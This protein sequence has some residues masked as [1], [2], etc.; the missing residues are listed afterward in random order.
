MKRTN[1]R[2]ENTGMDSREQRGKSEAPTGKPRT[3]A[4]RGGW[5]SFQRGEEGGQREGLVQNC[6]RSTLKAPTHWTARGAAREISIDKIH[7]LA[8]GGAGKFPVQSSK[9]TYSSKAVSN[10]QLRPRGALGPEALMRGPGSR[11]MKR[12]RSL[13]IIGGG[14]RQAVIRGCPRVENYPK[15]HTAM[16][17][18]C[19]IHGIFHLSRSYPGAKPPTFWLE[20]VV[21]FTFFTGG[22]KNVSGEAR[23]YV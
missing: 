5:V 9:S 15:Q 11:G 12:E 14:R 21:Q 16:L 7:H 17:P 23:V 3:S 18:D 4:K 22:K 20:A 6:N 13:R 10:R 2:E 8:S 19:L 1:N